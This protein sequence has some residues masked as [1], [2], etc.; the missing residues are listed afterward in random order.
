[1]GI[2][3]LLSGYFDCNSVLLGEAISSDISAS[4]SHSFP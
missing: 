3:L 2:I 1:M 4:V